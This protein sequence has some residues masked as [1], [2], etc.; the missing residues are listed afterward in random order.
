MDC[1][2]NYKY[3]TRL[4]LLYKLKSIKFVLKHKKFS[5]LQKVM[6]ICKKNISAASKLER[7]VLSTNNFTF[8]CQHETI[9]VLQG[10]H[11]GIIEVHLQMEEVLLMG[12]AAQCALES[13]RGTVMDDSCKTPSLFSQ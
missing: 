7:V 8:V 2:H 10:I 13:R 12:G 9:V 11:Q 5:K 1:V 6:K 3:K 4:A